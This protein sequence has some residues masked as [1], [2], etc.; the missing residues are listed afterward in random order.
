MPALPFHSTGLSDVGRRRPH[1]E[2]AFNIDDPLGLF[3]VADGVGGNAMGEVASR[4][5]VEQIHGFVSQGRGM[6]DRFRSA[7]SDVGR[8]MVRR[9]VESA[10]Q[11]AC[12]MVFGMGEVDP[13]QRGMSTT[14]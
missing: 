14:I 13:S 5:S 1:N 4:E 2:D 9:L 8:E 6:L 12:Y 10:V 11:N 3:V 7:P